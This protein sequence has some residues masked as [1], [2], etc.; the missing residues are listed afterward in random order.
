VEKEM[1][2]VYQLN[3]WKKERPPF[4][5]DE[6]LKTSIHELSNKRDAPWGWPELEHYFRLFPGVKTIQTFDDKGKNPFLTKILH[7]RDPLS[8][9]MCNKLLELNR[10]GA[11]IYLTINETDG[12]GRLAGSVVKVRAAFADLDQA[13]LYP[14]LK[15]DPTLVTESSPGRFHCYWFASDIPKEAFTE[16]QK[17]I[18]IL[19]NSDPKVHDL[20]RVLRIPGFFH[21]KG[22][23]F[24]SK[25]YGGSG[26]HYTYRSLVEMFPPQKVKKLSNIRYIHSD[27]ENTEGDFKGGYGVSAGMR[28]SHL[29]QIIGGML[30]RK[31]SWEYIRDEA[32]KDGRSSSPPLCDKEIEAVLKSAMRYKNY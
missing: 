27:K 7:F 18:A 31:C 8:T 4:T 14:A 17:S 19:L 22:D 21:L 9:P 5:E 10:S 30:K 13:P 29:I 1:K 32:F 28:N 20:S 15:Y 26:R 11:G 25:I 2:T 6:A 24:L 3:P 23:G 16:L 12:T